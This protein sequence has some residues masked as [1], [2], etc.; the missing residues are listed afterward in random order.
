MNKARYTSPMSSE[1][2]TTFTEALE[3]S[4]LMVCLGAILILS[5]VGLTAAG[6]IALG[7]GFVVVGALIEL[8]V[9][10]LAAAI[11]G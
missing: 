5:G 4:W 9:L 6:A 8:V 11:S 7:K 1:N 2:I 10:G 3:A